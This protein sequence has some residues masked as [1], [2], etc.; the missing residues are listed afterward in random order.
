V[1]LSDRILVMSPEERTVIASIDVPGGRPRLAESRH[2]QL[3]QQLVASVQDLVVG[4]QGHPVS[5]HA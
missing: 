2:S 3:F 4:N 5:D 1:F